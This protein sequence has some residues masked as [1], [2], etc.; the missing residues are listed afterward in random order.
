MSVDRARPSIP[1]VLEGQ[2][3]L[4]EGSAALTE[5]SGA[6]SV[7]S[8]ARVSSCTWLIWMVTSRQIC[9]IDI[10]L[11]YTGKPQSPLGRSS[12]RVSR[13]LTT[14]LHPKPAGCK[15][16]LYKG[17]VDKLLHP[18]GLPAWALELGNIYGGCAACHIRRVG[19]KWGN[20]RP[21][22]SS[23]SKPL[24]AFYQL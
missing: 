19:C 1:T 15:C 3:Q 13:H 8:H 7:Y 20:P 16:C 18:E 14:V 24:P 4:T 2:E 23:S 10:T 11:P 9:L 21:M 5:E 22:T 6:N 12:Q 17:M